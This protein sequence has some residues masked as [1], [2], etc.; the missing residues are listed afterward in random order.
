MRFRRQVV[1]T[2][3]GRP[4]ALHVPE[5]KIFVAD[6]PEQA[7]IF[8]AHLVLAPAR[9]AVPGNDHA[10]RPGMLQPAVALARRVQQEEVAVKIRRQT[11]EIHVRCADLLDVVA[12]ARHV[13]RLPPSNSDRMG[14]TAD[15]KFADAELTHF[16]RMIYELCVVCRAIAAETINGCMVPLHGGSDAPPFTVRLRRRLDV[17][18]AGL[19]SLADGLE[20]NAR[21]VEVSVRGVDMGAAHTLVEGEYLDPDS[22]R[23][24]RRRCQPP[25]LV[26]F[27]KLHAEPVGLGPNRHDVARVIPDQVATGSPDGH[28][29]L[30][31]GR[32]RLRHSKH[33]LD[34]VRRGTC[35]RNA[36]FDRPFHAVL[37]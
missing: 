10:R 13:R 25:A 1:G 19:V 9:Q 8:F 32:V 5:V 12:K 6:E 15:R 20:K 21:P 37:R 4:Q 27:L 18:L 36:I 33:H 11:E 17:D 7:A 24:A 31:P 14:N 16:D 35:R 22:E 29:E 2:K 23:F 26:Q 28:C 3:S 30:L 34:Q